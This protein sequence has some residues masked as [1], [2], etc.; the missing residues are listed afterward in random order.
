[1]PFLGAGAGF[2]PAPPPAF[3]HTTPLLMH[4]VS[5]SALFGREKRV[6]LGERLG[7]DGGQL[8]LEV[9]N[10]ARNLVDVG[11]R[12][13]CFDGIVECRLLLAQLLR[14]GFGRCACGIHN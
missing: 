10:L 2:V 7:A 6:Y 14:D 8:A 11:I 1:M 3:E 9:S 12:L 13:A 4:L 5:L